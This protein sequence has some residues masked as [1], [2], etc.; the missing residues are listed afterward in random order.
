MWG[1]RGKEGGKFQP[2]IISLVFSNLIHK[3]LFTFWSAAD[4]V[5]LPLGSRKRA[6]LV[7]LPGWRAQVSV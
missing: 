3:G 5:E 4:G 2:L 1:G 7:L 6:V